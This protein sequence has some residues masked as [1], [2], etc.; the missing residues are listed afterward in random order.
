MSLEN[1]LDLPKELLDSDVFMDEEQERNELYKIRLH[2]YK[3]RFENRYSTFVI[4]P[5]YHCNFNCVYCYESSRPAVY[6]D[7][8]TENNIVTFV[9]NMNLKSFHITWFGGEP[10]LNFKRIESLTRKI[11]TRS[12]ERRVGKECRSRWSPY[13]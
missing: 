8:E 6:M 2:T 10:L 5:T 13:H 11:T 3:K 4:V 7:E 9:E 12:E 1:I